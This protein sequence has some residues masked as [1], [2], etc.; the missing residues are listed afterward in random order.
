MP[1]FILQVKEILEEKGQTTQSLFDNKIVPENTFYKYKQRY[2]SLNTLIKIANYLHVSIDYLLGMSDENKFKTYSKEQKNLYN[3][4]INLINNSKISQRKFSKD[5]NYSR[6]NLQ[7][8]KN[9]MKPNIQ[10]LIEISN[11]F[12]VPINDLL[13]KE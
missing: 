8:W 12:N 5:L 3:N 9:G 6:V 11:Y 4:I 13:D 1:N 7:R 2:P 10:T